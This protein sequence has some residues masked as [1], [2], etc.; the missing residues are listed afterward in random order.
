MRYDVTP[1]VQHMERAIERQAYVRPDVEITVHTAQGR[2]HRGYVS[3]LETTVLI[4]VQYVRGADDSFY[5]YRRYFYHVIRVSDVV[6]F[7]IEGMNFSKAETAPR[8][9]VPLAPWM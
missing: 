5:R 9:G 7:T 3:Y 8:A 2:S 6:G 1:L 4:L